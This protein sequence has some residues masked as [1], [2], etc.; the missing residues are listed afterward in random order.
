MDQRE[1]QEKH[2]M[3]FL[4]MASDYKRHEKVYRPDGYGK[5]TGDCGDTVAMSLTTMKNTIQ[6]VSLEIDG[7]INTNACA[8]TVA[9][10]VEGKTIDEAWEMSPEQVIEFLETLPAESNHC[11][12]LAVGALF[13]ALSDFKKKPVTKQ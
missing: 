9:Q 11:A 13:L 6:H 12:E 5:N 7:C 1:F 10:F 8:N 2:S 4:Q 3:Q